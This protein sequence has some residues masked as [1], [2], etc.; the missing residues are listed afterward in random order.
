MELICKF[1]AKQADDKK[2]CLLR[3]VAISDN[4][5]VLITDSK[6][7]NIKV[8]HPLNLLSQGETGHT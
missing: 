1:Y 7:R 8:S 5:E 4:G 2:R 3:D 6:N